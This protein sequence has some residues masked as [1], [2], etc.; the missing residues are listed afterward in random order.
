LPPTLT[1]PASCSILPARA[2]N[3][4]EGVSAIKGLFGDGLF[5]LDGAHFHITADGLPTRLHRV[6]DGRLASPTSCV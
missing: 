1:W 2:S 6:G 4:I 3:A 5:D